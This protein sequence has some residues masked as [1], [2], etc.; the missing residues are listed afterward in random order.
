MFAM[1]VTAAI[2]VIGASV[3]AAEPQ[4]NK[5]LVE[6]SCDNGQKYAFVLN[7]EGNAG[8][9]EGSTSN[10]I[11]V[12]YTVTYL[13]AETEEQVAN[14]TFDQGEKKGM[15][16]DL[17]SCT[18]RTTFDDWRMG[19]VVSVFDFQALLTPQRR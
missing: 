16:G 10:I 5:V 1:V 13:D 15:E 17:I 4:K 6:A 3:A 2:L 12:R 11:P 14:Y 9:I 7:G 19:E 18:G 8:H